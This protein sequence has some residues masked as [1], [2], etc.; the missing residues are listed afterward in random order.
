[1]NKLLGIIFIILYWNCSGESASNKGEKDQAAKIVSVSAFGEVQNYTFKVGI[2]S[3]DLGCDQYA[4]WWEVVDLEGN[5]IYRRI[6]L[7]SHVNEQPFVRSG[8]PVAIDENQTVIVRAHMNNSGYG[9]QAFQGNIK[10]GFQQIKLEEGF[11][12]DLET[13]APLPSECA[14]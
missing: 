6:L 13:Q 11:A 1:M 3:P 7:H 4:D 9:M 2:S 8:G 10:K 5:L 14:F 12:A